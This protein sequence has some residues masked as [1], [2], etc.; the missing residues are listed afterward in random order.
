MIDIV[1]ILL[2]VLAFLVGLQSLFFFIEVVASLR[3]EPE[4]VA[5]SAPRSD[6]LCVLIPAHD[7]SGLIEKTVTALRAQLTAQDRLLVLADNCSDDTAEKARSAGAEVIERQDRQKIGKGYA[8]DCGIRH[9]ARGAPPSVVVFVD[10]DCE[11]ATGS[12]AALAAAC[13]S[14]GRPVQATNLM[15]ADPSAGKTTRIAQFAWK[16]KNYVRPLGAERLGLPCQLTGT[17]MAIP[18]PLLASVELSTGHIAEDAKLGVE[19]AV[20][21]HAPRFCPPARVTSRFPVSARG[22]KEQRIRWE[23][24]HLT[25]IQQH[26]P[27]LLRNAW[28]KR[29][30]ELLALAID[31]SIQPLGLFLLTTSALA[32]AGVT[33]TLL[34]ASVYFGATT[35]APLALFATAIGLAWA[36]H[37]RSIVSSSDLLYAPAYALSKLPTLWRFLTKRQ[38][39]WVRAERNIE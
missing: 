28:T 39:V 37:G 2:F 31:L 33:M 8:L 25:M 13:S 22:I 18:W 15:E 11:L 17:G 3:G 6:P 35:S 29:R 24:G 1:A 36:R 16:V 20:Q 4:T 23:H 26:V 7:E 30:P 32:A 34:G 12:I 19:L 9:L 14:R 21:G 27:Y 5:A 38:V 10:A